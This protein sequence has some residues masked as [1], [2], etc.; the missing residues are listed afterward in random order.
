MAGENEGAA[1]AAKKGS[2][3]LPIIVVTLLMLGE[4]FV[5]Y[6]IANAMAPAPMEGVAADGGGGGGGAGDNNEVVEI[7]LAEST[8][9]NRRSGKLV[10]FR[11]RVTGLVKTEDEEKARELVKIRQARLLDRINYVVRSAEP[12]HLDEPELKTIRRRLKQEF[13]A[14]LGEGMIVDV[15]IPEYHQ[16]SAGL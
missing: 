10:N 13:D 15:I 9:N 1:A 8:T 5:V 16:S 2:K 3:L 7:E 4:G 14:I 11:L 6:F 12:M